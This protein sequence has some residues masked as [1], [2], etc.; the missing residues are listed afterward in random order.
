MEDSLEFINFKDFI[1]L[2]ETYLKREYLAFGQLEQEPDIAAYKKNSEA[3]I[4]YLN[5]IKEKMMQ[6]KNRA[7]ELRKKYNL[8]IDLKGRVNI[9]LCRI[10]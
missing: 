4:A 7:P 6:R 3:T 5:L 2:K 10:C 9:N 8:N 1:S